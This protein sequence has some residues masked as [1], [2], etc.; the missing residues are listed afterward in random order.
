MN[1]QKAGARFITIIFVF[2]GLSGIVYEII[3]A[4]FFG[5]VFGNTVFASSTVLSVFMTGLA[6]GSWLLGKFVDRQKDALKI[7]VYLETGIG[8]SGLLVPLCIHASTPLYAF[9]FRHFD[10][11]FYQLSLIRLAVSFLILIVPCTLMGGTLPVISRFISETF[12]STTPEKQVGRLYAAN[13][14]GAVLGCLIA[15]YFLIG[16]AGL[17][18]TTAIAALVNFSIAAALFLYGR[19]R[20][21][22][23]AAIKKE[24]PEVSGKSPDKSNDSDLKSFQLNIVIAAYGLCGFLSLFLEVAWTRALVWVMGMDAYAFASM[25]AVFLSG[26]ALG[27]YL[28]SR[29]VN[30]LSGAII[31]L[32]VIEL[33][34]GMSVLFSTVMINNMYGLMAGIERVFPM[35]SFWGA[36]A[37]FMTIAAVIMA[38]PTLF[39]GM[40][41]PLALRISFDGRMAVGAGVGTVYAANTIGSVFGALL[42]GFV[43][44]PLIGVMKSIVLAGGVFLLVA[45]VLFMT[46]SAC[47]TPAVLH[48]GRT[49]GFAAAIMCA[50]ASLFLMF[51]YAPDLQKALKRG[52][53]AGEKLLYFKETVTGGVEVTENA[54]DGR[55]LKIDGR[56]VASDGQSDVASHKYPAHLM[57]ALHK[58]PLN[59]LVIAFG[60]GG[61]SGSL[62][63]YDEVKHLDAVEICDGVIE[64]A[65]QYFTKMNNGVLNDPRL[66]L[67]IQDGKNFVQLTDKTYDII[68]SGP[69]HPQ[70]NQG[71]AALYTKDFFEDCRKR[72][73]RGGLQC[74]WLPLHV[75]VEDYKTIVRTFLEVFPHSSLWLTTNSP[76]TVIHTHL[77][78]SNEPLD[79]DFQMVNEKLHKGK[80]AIDDDQMDY[81]TLTDAFDV[82]NQC[83]I[84]EQK[85]REFTSDIT[86][87][88]TDNLPAAEFFRKIGRTTYTKEESP[89]LLL[90]E[91]LRFKENGL[92]YV[93]AISPAEKTELEE[94]LTN[95]CKGDSL[96]IE[97][98]IAY[99]RAFSILK[100]KASPDYLT[101]SYR[102][103]SD[104]YRCYSAAQPC[105]PDDRFLK[106]FFVEA[107]RVLSR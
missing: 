100:E 4:R 31:K 28:V 89:T 15:G 49:A 10:P 85:L 9:V 12:K 41:F 21:D 80:E 18:G 6:L 40:A 52:L 3:W 95:Y 60:A 61:T 23:L 71:S 26:L 39:M 37:F 51:F 44:L 70:S 24:K 45:A 107:S 54:T 83:A 94:K 50:A 57:V 82:V 75:P 29:F 63:R 87:L 55:S 62:L 102:W 81:I 77:I 103:Y 17:T 59:V 42:A 14:L 7:Y 47:R 56:Q 5:L 64:P 72:L 92:A 32:A 74:V 53:P 27:S 106:E 101:E 84:G 8:L 13:T 96:R 97:G 93:T 76:N 78:G 22:T 69:I 35:T 98:H 104:A 43:A 65:R 48:A 67:I 73:N 38:L 99:M 66:H 19:R 91:I 11:S 2:S 20:P 30:D 90:P 16:T 88:N 105:L 34:I 58:H 25:L 33:L 68:Y 86:R 1:L 79:I 36:A 46:A